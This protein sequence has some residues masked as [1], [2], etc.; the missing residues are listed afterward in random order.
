M[1]KKAKDENA[2]VTVY[3]GYGW[4]AAMV[5]HLLENE[6]IEAF[7]NNE[8]LSTVAPMYVSAGA[9]GT[10]TVVVARKDLERAKP[11]VAQYEQ[12]YSKKG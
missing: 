4:E 9:W 3:T 12:K 5:K 2:P 11:I 1:S 6:G 10:V 8:N 7:L